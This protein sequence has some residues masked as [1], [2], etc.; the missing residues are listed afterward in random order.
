MP[1]L[2]FQLKEVYKLSLFNVNQTVASK[3]RNTSTVPIKDKQFLIVTDS[4][5]IFYEIKAVTTSGCAWAK[6]ERNTIPSIIR[7]LE[8]VVENMMCASPFSVA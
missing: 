2:L 5:D 4:G 7:L 8:A 6:S 3:A 1:P